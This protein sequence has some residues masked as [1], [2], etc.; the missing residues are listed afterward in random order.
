[1][2]QQHTAAGDERAAAARHRVGQSLL[3][4]RERLTRHEAGAI[5]GTF[6]IE[7]PT[8]AT[9]RILAMAG[10][11][12]VVIDLEHSTLTLAAAEPLL[13]EARACGLSTLVRVPPDH[14]SLIGN[15]LDSGANGVMVPHVDS[16]EQ[17]KRVV[18]HTRFAP[19]G[20]RGFSPLTITRSLDEPQSAM[21]HGQ[22]VVVQIE[23]Q[24]GLANA[25][26][27][28]SI[29][30]IDAVF[31]GP[32]DL[33]EA[34]GTPSDIDSPAVLEAAEK[35]ARSVPKDRLVGI[36]MDNPAKSAAWLKRGFRLQCVS[37]DGQMLAN[38]AR[39]VI[40]ATE[41]EGDSR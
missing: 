36:Y 24:A 34:L 10:F 9:I 13:A 41:G 28:A 6:L 16:V 21:N 39:E 7:L 18:R 23:G 3:S 32:Y 11:S 33:A 38:R 29:A 31:V 22:I 17:A 2:S 37:F 8:V 26:A 27:I 14:L 30:G 20:E 35:V 1:M 4:F 12:F 19:I 15:A 40:R 5:V 25:G